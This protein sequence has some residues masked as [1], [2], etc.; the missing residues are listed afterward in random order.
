MVDIFLKI[1]I[2]IFK[3][4]LKIYHVK[5]QNF[6]ID[7]KIFIWLQSVLARFYGLFVATAI[8]YYLPVALIIL[9][10]GRFYFYV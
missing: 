5:A 4:S 6:N 9:R 8:S 3:N 1:G 2:L 7:K 10:D